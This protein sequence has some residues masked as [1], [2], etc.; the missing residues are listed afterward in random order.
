MAVNGYYHSAL[1]EAT[2]FELKI[3]L[4]YFA[5]W[6]R[7]NFPSAAFKLMI[8]RTRCLCPEFYTLSLHLKYK[9]GRQEC[10][11]AQVTADRHQSPL[12]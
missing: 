11:P 1:R 5:E 12:N 3:K 10:L 8:L 4:F 7:C 9:K 2:L 6:L